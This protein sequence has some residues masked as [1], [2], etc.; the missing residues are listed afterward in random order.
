MQ[1]EHFNELTP[2][3]AERLAVLSEELGEAQQAVGKI[4]RHGYA[5][6]H[7]SFPSVSNRQN[8]M[9]EL[10]DIT[11][12]MSMLGDAGDINP[13]EVCERAIEKAEKIGRYLHHAAPPAIEGRPTN[14]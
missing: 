7:P 8:L 3:Q 12:A 9:R 10:G 11:A 2:A 6:Y 4:L 13:V 5:S 1:D 14:G